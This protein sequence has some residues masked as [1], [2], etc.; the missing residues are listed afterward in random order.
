MCPLALSAGQM[1]VERPVADHVSVVGMAVV[2]GVIGRNTYSRGMQSSYLRWYRSWP[3]AAS[4]PMM[5]LA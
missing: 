1:R 3:A 2:K 4:P 5:A